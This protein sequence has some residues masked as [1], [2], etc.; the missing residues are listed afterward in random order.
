MPLAPPAFWSPRRD[1][2]HTTGSR[3]PVCVPP[4]CGPS[5]VSQNAAALNPQAGPPGA[6]EATVVVLVEDG[7]AA[8]VV[9]DRAVVVVDA[10]AVVVGCATVVVGCAAV[11]V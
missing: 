4:L 1:T 7:A 3:S 8:V 10:R 2:P 9:V 11:V 6:V 5:N